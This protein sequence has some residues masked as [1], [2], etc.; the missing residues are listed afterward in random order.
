MNPF[1][2]PWQTLCALFLVGALAV[3]SARVCL[4][5]GEGQPAPP[6][7][8]SQEPS[9]AVDLEDPSQ[10]EDELPLQSPPDESETSQ[11]AESEPPAAATPADTDQTAQTKSLANPSIKLKGVVWRARPGIIFLKTPIGLLSL[12]SKSTLKSLPA[13]QEV[14]FWI[15]EHHLAVD[16]VKRADQTLV[17]RYL[18]GP[19]VRSGED[20]KKLLCWTPE[21]NKAFQLGTQAKALAARRDGESVTVEVDHT[22]TVI[23]VHDLQF[24]IQ[25]SQLPPSGSDVQL[26]LTGTISKLKSNFIFFKTP[27]GIINVNAKIGIKNAKVGQTL[28]LQIHQHHLVA[29]LSADNGSMSIRRFLTGP[30]DFATPDR[31]SIRLWTPNGEQTYPTDIG[32]A[33]LVG[34]KPGNPITVELNGAGHVVDVFRSQ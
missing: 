9:E 11:P 3:V 8:S 1:S 10:N 21:G 19:I 23:G 24:D 33:A 28:T 26:L 31:T 18:S 27:I 30:L 20:G 13:S 34:A 32:K 17:H 4:A 12:S 15:H 14:H 7:S 22:D 16:I 5:Q 2:Q 29:D 6:P 25:I